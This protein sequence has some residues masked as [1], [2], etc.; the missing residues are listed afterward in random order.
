[1]KLSIV[2]PDRKVF[3]ADDVEAVYAKTTD[4]E[5]GILQ[6]HV[7]MVTPLDIGIL[8]FVQNGE[9]RSLAIMGGILRTNGQEVSVLADAAEL[10]DEIDSLRAEKAKER[11]EA[12]LRQQSAEVDSTRAKMAL[13][14]SI[15]RLKL[16]KSI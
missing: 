9:K 2:T 13:T 15:T 4:G 5:V 1:M 6:K 10:S 11:A 3:E 14:R 8:R 7:P 16:S 12:R